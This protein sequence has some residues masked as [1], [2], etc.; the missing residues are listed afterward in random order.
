M[1]SYHVSLGKI[2]LYYRS[3]FL[4]HW[5]ECMIGKFVLL[6]TFAKMLA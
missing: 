2:D 3:L 5:L 6:L 1:A 4:N